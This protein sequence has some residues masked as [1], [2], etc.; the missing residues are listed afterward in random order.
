M[1]TKII[2][3]FSGSLWEAE[4]IKSLLESTNIKS[5]LKNSV[6][7]TYFYDPIVSQGVK[8]MILESDFEI[9]KPIVDSYFENLN[10]ENQ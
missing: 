5:F 10:N 9:A 4:M 7:N 2:E 3:I 1:D 8:V 6:L